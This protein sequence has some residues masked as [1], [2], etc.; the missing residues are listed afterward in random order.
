[1]RFLILQGLP[2]NLKFKF[3]SKHEFLNFALKSNFPLCIS[4]KSHVFGIN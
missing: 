2:F 3:P 1:M 4:Y